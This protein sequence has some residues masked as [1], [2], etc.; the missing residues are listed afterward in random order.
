[1]RMRFSRGTTLQHALILPAVCY[2]YILYYA[3]KGSRPTA[4][5]GA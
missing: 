1:M 5:A 2:L 4:N 3:L